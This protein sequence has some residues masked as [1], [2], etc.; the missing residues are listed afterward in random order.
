MERRINTDFEFKTCI[1][2]PQR[3]L[4]SPFQS[5]DCSRK[6]MRAPKLSSEFEGTFQL[7][8]RRERILLSERNIAGRAPRYHATAWQSRCSSSAIIQRCV[9]RKAELPFTFSPFSL[10]GLEPTHRAL[11]RR[12]PR[13]IKPHMLQ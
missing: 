7:T 9:R 10:A 12:L 8:L 11:L 5:S 4:L 2:Q 13:R 6:N 3:N 1:I